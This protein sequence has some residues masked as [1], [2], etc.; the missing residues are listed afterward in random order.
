MILFKSQITQLQKVCRRLAYSQTMQE[1]DII[2]SPKNE[3]KRAEAEQLIY[4]AMNLL[5]EI[6]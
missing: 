3:R 2:L 1:K 4:K 6:K 5:E